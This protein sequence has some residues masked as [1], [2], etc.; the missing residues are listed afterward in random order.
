MITIEQFLMG[1][2]KYE[3]LSPVMQ[4]DATDLLERVNLL[5]ADFYRD[6]PDVPV[7]TV[8]SGYRRPADNASAGGAKLS[9]HMICQAID[10]SDAD[11]KLGRWFALFPEKLIKFDL[12]MEA[13]SAT[14]T[15]IHLQ[16]Q[17]PKSK[18]RTF[19][20]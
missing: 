15:W 6:F 1:R 18:K 5:L 17:P 16:L 14:P 12:Y 4:A 20:P 3:E 2:I 11:N 9:K 7:R 13:K 10:L 8:N 19:N